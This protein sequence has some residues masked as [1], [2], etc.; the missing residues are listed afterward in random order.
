MSMMRPICYFRKPLY[1]IS[2]NPS[3]ENGLLASSCLCNKTR[4]ESFCNKTCFI[5]RGKTQQQ[6]QPAE[7]NA[8]IL[9]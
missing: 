7:Y 4:L 8:Y 9:F 5:K 3:N 2:E 1:V 6:Q